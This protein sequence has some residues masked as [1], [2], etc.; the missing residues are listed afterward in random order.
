MALSRLVPT[1]YKATYAA[2][3]AA[4]ASGVEGTVTGGTEVTSGNYKYHV[5]TSSG[6][7]TIDGGYKEMEVLMVGGGGGGGYGGGGCGQIVHD[8]IFLPTGDVTVTIGAGGHYAGWSSA[9]DANG[10]VTS[11]TKSN[12]ELYANGGGGG[13]SSSGNFAAAS[14]GGGG[15][16]VKSANSGGTQYNSLRDG[17]TGLVE[18]AATLNN[19]S[20]GIVNIK[21]ADYG[22]K[23]GN[24]SG[25][26]LPGKINSAGGGGA[27]AAGTASTWDG[28]E[29]K[30]GGAGTGDF[31]TWLQAISGSVNIGEDSGGVLY[32]CG[33]GGG[34]GY[35]NGYRAG[36]GGLGGGGNGRVDADANSGGGGGGLAYGGSGFVIIRYAV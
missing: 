33:G 5:F 2:T 21:H 35:N 25:T 27:S 26:S 17:G 23:G 10:N 31:D 19:S 30:A 29:G 28:G 16:A 34:A 20:L 12:W 3:Q 9:W 7:L 36:G 11:L 8:Y 32:I 22:Y 18:I 6:T 4:K 15:G 1:A 13:G 14:G 24:Q